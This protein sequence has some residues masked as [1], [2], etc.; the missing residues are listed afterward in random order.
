MR[1]GKGATRR[2]TIY[3]FDP[4]VS[5]VYALS[6]PAVHAPLRGP[7]RGRDSADAAQH[8]AQHYNDIHTSA[9]GVAMSRA[10]TRCVHKT[11]SLASAT[12][13]SLAASVRPCCRRRSASRLLATSSRSRAPLQSR[14]RARSL[15]SGPTSHEAWI[16]CLAARARRWT[17]SEAIKSRE[18]TR[19]ISISQFGAAGWLD[20]R[21]DGLS[22]T[23]RWCRRCS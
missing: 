21:P 8:F 22:T 11:R 23:R 16:A 5:R 14:N 15:L 3:A 7:G 13:T 10:S 1:I 2:L 9:N 17:K 19:Y 4:S 6:S 18:A 12:R 20:M